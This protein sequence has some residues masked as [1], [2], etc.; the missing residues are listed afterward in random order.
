MNYI[1]GTNIKFTQ[2][3][4]LVMGQAFESKV[5]KT[6]YLRVSRCYR[7]TVRKLGELR[8]VVVFN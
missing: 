3:I 4:K 2:K 6:L 8:L 5:W 7:A 1:S